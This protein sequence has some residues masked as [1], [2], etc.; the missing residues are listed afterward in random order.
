MITT[1]IS[2]KGQV[3]LPKALRELQ[4]WDPGTEL[5]LVPM[6]GG[7]FMHPLN[8][9]PPSRVEDVLGSVKYKGKPKSLAEIK[10]AWKKMVRKRHAS[11]R[12]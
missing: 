5:A 9:F 6:D 10:N 4:K 8:P 2:S 12:Y 1:R 11:G 7:I 3:V